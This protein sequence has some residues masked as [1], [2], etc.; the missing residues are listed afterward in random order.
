VKRLE[1]LSAALNA[2]SKS[3]TAAKAKVFEDPDYLAAKEKQEQAYA[4]RKISQTLHETA[5]KRATVL[6]RELTRR[7]GR[8]PRESRAGRWSA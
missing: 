3:V 5:D 1:G 6:S 7:V 8:E 2:G 4:Y